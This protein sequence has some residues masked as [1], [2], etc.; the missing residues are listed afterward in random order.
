MSF[1][2]S[3]AGAFLLG[4]T[5]ATRAVGNFTIG[6]IVTGIL[7]II[8][9]AVFQIQTYPIVGIVIAVAG[10]IGAAKLG[11]PIPDT[12]AITEKLLGI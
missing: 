5:P 2:K 6:F 12:S 10:G 1:F 9:A 11:I 7:V 8:A 3:Y 4:E